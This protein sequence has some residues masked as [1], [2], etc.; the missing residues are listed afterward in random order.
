MFKMCYEDL[1]K[2][3]PKM[4]YI[5][6]KVD[7]IQKALEY[8]LYECALTLAMTL[9]DI[10]AKVAFKDD[11]HFYKEGKWL[12][13]ESYKQWFEDYVSIYFN[14]DFPIQNE[15]IKYGFTGEYLKFTSEYCY[16]LRCFLLHEGN[17]EGIAFEKKADGVIYL[18]GLTELSACKSEQLY[19]NGKLA[20]KGIE[21]NIRELCNGIISGVERFYMK[22]DSDKFEK[23]ELKI[24]RFNNQ[25]DLFSRI[26]AK[27]LDFKNNKK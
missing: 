12:V 5:Q 15:N 17:I 10:C 21:I 23:Y 14:N 4:K 19:S 20:S 1:K 6:N 22:V 3:K 26:K 9:P 2:E 13:G 25:Y 8:G 11:Q 24:N 18:F 7:E 27:D 16:H